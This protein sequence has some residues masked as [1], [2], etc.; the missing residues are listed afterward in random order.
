[1]HSG[2]YVTLSAQ[3]ALERRMETI[4]HNVANMNTAGYRSE[5]VTFEQVL[6]RTGD[7]PVAYVSPGTDYIARTNGEVSKTGGSLD[8][9]VQGD[10][11][12]AVRTPAGIA[13]TRDGRM[14]M[15]PTGELRSVNGYPILDIGGAPLR[16]DP[17]A[18]LATIAGDGMINQG[19]NQVGALGLFKIDD[20]ARLTRF[21]NSG[22]LPETPPAAILDFSTNG[23][24]QGSLEG[25]NVNPVMEIAKLVDVQR[26][27]DS[28]ATMTQ[29]NESS[30]QDAIKTLGSSS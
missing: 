3:V 8:V 27:F 13:Y 21:D 28:L 18:G 25:A 20:A 6:S 12:L 9:A 29:S 1:M 5:K 14:N 15:T 26:T 4:S 16:L 23:V 7:R 22:V 19:T 17:N 11:W 2:L 10:G 30:L 24:I